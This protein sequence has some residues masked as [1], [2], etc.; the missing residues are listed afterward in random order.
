MNDAAYDALPDAAYDAT[1][2]AAWIDANQRN[3]V[4]ELNR[5]AARLAPGTAAA[6][7]PP[8]EAE[9]AASGMAS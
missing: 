9:P 7:G 3:L 4:D 5:L 8:A 6:E 1:P 2:D